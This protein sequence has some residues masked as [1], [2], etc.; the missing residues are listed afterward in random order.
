MHWVKVATLNFC[1]SAAFLVQQ[2]GLRL[3][4][5]LGL[6][7]VNWCIML[8]SLVTDRRHS[9]DSGFMHNRV[10]QSQSMWSS[11]IV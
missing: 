6:L 8:D 11:L 3:L 7:C 4:V 9:L 1:G 2:F 10:A 5:F